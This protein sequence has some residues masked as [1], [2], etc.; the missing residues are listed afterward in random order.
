MHV[1]EHEHDV[2]VLLGDGVDEHGADGAR[3]PE[4]LVAERHVDVEAQPHGGGEGARERGQLGVPGVE[5]DPDGGEVGGLEPVDDERG[6][7]VSGGRRD[8]DALAAD[9]ARR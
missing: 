5:R 4:A 9:C 8:E 7:A 3:L 6:L 2:V 1:V